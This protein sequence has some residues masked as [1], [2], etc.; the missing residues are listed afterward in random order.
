MSPVTLIF[1]WHFAFLVTVTHYIYFSTNQVVIT[2][3][4]AFLSSVKFNIK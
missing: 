4:T 1:E 3:F 2:D